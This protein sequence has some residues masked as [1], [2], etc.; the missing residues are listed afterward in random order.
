MQV[1]LRCQVGGLSPGRRGAVTGPSVA[2]VCTMAAMNA[3]KGDIFRVKQRTT[4]QLC[5]RE[6]PEDEAPLVVQKP[7]TC[8]FIPAVS[9]WVRGW[10]GHLPRSLPS[11]ARRLRAQRSCQRGL[12]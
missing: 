9:R 12:Q 2:A 7:M 11:G 6:K 3:A 4:S 1:W 10:S 5:P 8:G